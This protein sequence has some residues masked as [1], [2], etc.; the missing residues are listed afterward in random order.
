M[1]H[2][3]ALLSQQIAQAGLTESVQNYRFAAPRLWR[4]DRAWPAEKVA[5]EVMGGVWTPRGGGHNR[6]A[7]YE[8]DCVK[9]AAASLGGWLVLY[10]T[11]RL[12]RKGYAVEWLR[13][14]LEH[15]QTGWTPALWGVGAFPPPSLLRPRR[16]RGGRSGRRS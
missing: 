13:L 7:G 5:L 3:E 1:S 2:L 9:L 14:A 16:V 10:A 11:E 15:R 6:G 12:I 4:F 8:D